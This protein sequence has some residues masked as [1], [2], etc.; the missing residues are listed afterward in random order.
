MASAKQLTSRC[1]RLWDAYYQRPTK[2]NLV[3]FGEH[4]EV[5]KS[6]K[7]S[8]VALERRRGVR[9]YNAEFKERGWVKP[10]VAKLAKP[11]SKR[12][13]NP[14]DVFSAEQMSEAGDKRF[15]K[16]MKTL[17]MGDPGTPPSE[18]SDEELTAL[19]RFVR[20]SRKS[21]RG[22]AAE[23]LSVIGPG[24]WH[25]AYRR[26]MTHLL[27]DVEIERIE[28]NIRFAGGV[29]WG[30][31]LVEANPSA[32][33]KKAKVR[34]SSSKKRAKPRA[35]P[36][37]KGEP[38]RRSGVR[39]PAVTKFVDLI[40]EYN[41]GELN[42]SHSA[43]RND[44][45]RNVNLSG[46]DFSGHTE[47][48]NVTFLAVDFDGSTW[49][50]TDLVN[51]MFTDVNFANS[52]FTMVDFSS[53]PVA[54]KNV[55]FDYSTITNCG[56]ASKGMNTVSFLQCSLTECELSAF[57]FSSNVSF[58]EALFRFCNFE[59]AMNFGVHPFKFAGATFDKGS[60]D[61]ASMEDFD[62]TKL[63]GFEGPFSFMNTN[64]AGADLSNATG[65]GGML[66]DFSNTE[67]T[68]VKFGTADLL[69]VDLS[70][71]KSIAGASF[72]LAKIENVIW[73]TTK[74]QLGLV[75]SINN[76]PSGIPFWV[77]RK[78]EAATLIDA[79]G[80]QA[81]QIERD[82][83][84][85]ELNLLLGEYKFAAVPVRKLRGSIK[86][87]SRP[88]ANRPELAVLVDWAIERYERRGLW[89]FFFVS[90]RKTKAIPD[91]KYNLILLLTED[92]DLF[93]AVEREKPFLWGYTAVVRDHVMAIR[94]GEGSSPVGSL[95]V[96]WSDRVDMVKAIAESV[97][98]GEIGSAL[99]GAPEEAIAESEEPGSTGY[100]HV[101]E[102]ILSALDKS[103]R[104]KGLA[105]TPRKGIMGSEPFDVFASMREPGRV[106]IRQVPDDPF[107]NPRNGRKK[108]KARVARRKRRAR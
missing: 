107:E 24:L 88:Y 81:F 5:M 35:K 1:Q 87:G 47:F 18:M 41:N 52:E 83:F 34:S 36:R 100:R 49:G 76:P 72:G 90:Y 62:T 53:Y 85:S 16:W 15:L 74:D 68:D 20:E 106:G 60:F 7:A 45:I 104:R 61:N 94:G 9:A 4:L 78:A 44:G 25:E 40:K 101:G 30:A 19:L 10:K 11:A 108:R 65:F 92:Y 6:S 28:S 82:F 46:I 97:E 27:S 96:T 75:S 29:P 93:S 71:V 77:I 80:T 103:R 66:T 32:A 42:F 73:P 84:K 69:G 26:G 98:H 91:L 55:K 99:R 57:D 21:A 95:A 8:S 56:F 14:L 54:M 58:K 105:P 67:L 3:A 17:G 23:T 37:V 59:D 33:A 64:L 63:K 48:A 31:S 79:E 89:T 43:I 102:E 39:N 86:T 38:R 12:R 22:M 2:K 13:R 51:A 70:R 50:G